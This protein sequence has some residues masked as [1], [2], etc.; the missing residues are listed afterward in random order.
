[1]AGVSDEHALKL[2]PRG[3]QSS[4]VP[5]APDQ[6]LAGLVMVLD[7]Q[8]SR[9]AVI[10]LREWSYERLAAQPGDLA[11][12]VGS[13]TGSEA[14]ELAT[15]VGSEGRAVGIEPHPGLRAEAVRRATEAGSTAEFVDASALELPFDDGSVDVLRCE[16]VFQH[17]A[18]PQ[19]V[20]NEFA[21]VLA[22]GGRVAIL[23]SDWATAVTTPGDPDVVR[24]LQET[25]WA[26]TPN[27]FSGRYLRAWLRRAG[28]E[29][30]PDIGSAAMVLSDDMLPFLTRNLLD[31]ALEARAVT[32]AEADAHEQETLAAMASGEAFMS[33]TMYA[34]IATKPA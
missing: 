21:R 18:D 19:G 30:D 4:H 26:R 7:A 15:R 32:S 6:E 23:D 5:S 3:F 29:V 22:P 16:R 27:P 20:A 13:G 11:V 2:D 31:E 25:M 10:R 1:M 12:D 9:P 28:L 14:M 24:R 8:A 33:V 34:A 17:L